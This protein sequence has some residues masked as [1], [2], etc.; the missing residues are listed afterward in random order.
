MLWH[1]RHSCPQC[2]AP[3]ELTET[4]HLLT[5][6][7]CRVRLFMA[8]S[9]M[10]RY[11]I[12]PRQST[13][14]ELFFIPYWRLK[15]TLFTIGPTAVTHR[16]MD[17]T[18]KALEL[19]QLPFSLGIRPQTMRL[20][21]AQTVSE[22]TFLRPTVPVA[23]AVATMAGRVDQIGGGV[24]SGGW[25]KYVGKQRSIIYA[26]CFVHQ[27]KLH[28]AVLG[29]AI[30]DAGLDAL[31]ECR[32]DDP[33]RWGISYLPALCPECGWDLGGAEKGLA[34]PCSGCGAGWRHGPGGPVKVQLE[35]VQGA[36]GGLLLPFWRVRA[37]GKG[38]ACSSYADLVRWANLPR[39]VQPGW[40][41]EPAWFVIPAFKL[42][43]DLFLRLATQLT[44]ARP[45]E[46]RPGLV[47]GRLHPAT[48]ALEEAE[49]SVKVV[50][51]SLASRKSLVLPSLGEREFTVTERRLLYLPFRDQGQELVLERLG[52]SLSRAA[53]EHGSLL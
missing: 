13:G 18:S 2:G 5:C 15:G 41:K 30:P 47:Q 46:A 40:E 28:D 36:G 53:L 3:I 4:E 32:P 26:P 48:L 38:E 12:P 25:R 14:R 49:R 22:G 29:R 7:F 17:A 39:I 50:F 10:F 21:F 45:G 33:L 24:R 44:V 11:V 52:I 1:I 31:K 42:R 35:S 27:G 9:G 37:E 43:P 8:P 23:S 6:P 19:L 20:A 16:L 51:A 34:F